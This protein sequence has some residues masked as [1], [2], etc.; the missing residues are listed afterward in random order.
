[1]KLHAVNEENAKL[2]NEVRHLQEE[3]AL[4]KKR[5]SWMENQ[6]GR[7]DGKNVMQVSQVEIHVCSD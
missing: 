7:D 2:K 4:M 6:K 1:M 3:F 5:V